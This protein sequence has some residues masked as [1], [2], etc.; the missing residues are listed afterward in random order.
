MPC[1]KRVVLCSF[2]VTLQKNIDVKDLEVQGAV[3]VRTTCPAI[4]QSLVR[5]LKQ[6]LGNFVSLE[7]VTGIDDKTVPELI[8]LISWKSGHLLEYF[9]ECIDEDT[10]PCFFKK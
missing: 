10:V 3:Y 9:E 8:T 2:E 5:M 7:T 4:L 1:E 6:I